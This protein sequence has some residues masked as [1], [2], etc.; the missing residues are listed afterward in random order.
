MA[1]GA[2]YCNNVFAGYLERRGAA[3]YVFTY[4]EAY[5]ADASRPPISLTIGKSKSEH[6]RSCC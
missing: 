6:K 5:Y 2:I 4:D 3:E 1:K